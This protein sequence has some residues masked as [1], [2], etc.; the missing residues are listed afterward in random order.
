V[1]TDLVN[2]DQAPVRRRTPAKR[3]ARELAKHLRGERPD[4][5]YLKEVLR[6]L[7]A[8]LDVPVTDHA[9]P[10]GDRRR[11]RPSAPAWC[12][13]AAA[14]GLPPAGHI[15]LAGAACGWCG[16]GRAD[17]RRHVRPARTR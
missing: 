15:A 14:T 11:C 12:A 2:A 1:S 8:E 4:Y 17:R 3:K 13:V 16:R 9:R 5:T 10:G 7:R 6:H